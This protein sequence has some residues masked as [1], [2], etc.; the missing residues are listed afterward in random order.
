MGS[1]SGAST[2]FLVAVGIASIVPAVVATYVVPLIILFVLGVLFCLFL[3]F[4]VAPRVFEHGWF[5]RAVFSWGWVTAS[6]ATG[7]AVLKIVD[8]KMRSGTLEEF[9]MAYVGFAPFEIAAAI[10][11]PM[12]IIAGLVWLFG[13]VGLIGGVVLLAIPMIA[14]KKSR[15]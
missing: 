13:I 11:A 7:I 4:Y 5:E 14:M 3:F 12:M 6:V 9:G 2:D 10:L 1:V 8:P 15:S